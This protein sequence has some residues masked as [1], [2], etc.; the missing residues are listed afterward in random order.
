MWPTSPQ[1]SPTGGTRRRS[2]RGP[3]PR[4]RSRWRTS[5]RSSAWRSSRYRGS[6]GRSPP[7]TICAPCAGAFDAFVLPS[8][9]EGTP[10]T[11]IEALAGARPV[12]ATRVGGVPDVVRDG[13][14][15]FLVDPEAVDEL[16]DRLARLAGNPDLRRRMG[17]AGQARVLER[18]SVQRLLDD[19]DR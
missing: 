4:A 19:V 10:V 6:R 11:T 5:P 7:C 2:S 3:W 18:Y 13:E 15:G 14:D 12:V 8:G 1:G 16:A 17:E 9:N